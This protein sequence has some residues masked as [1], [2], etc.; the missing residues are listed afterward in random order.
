[1]RRTGDELPPHAAGATG[2]AAYR[3]AAV[4]GERPAA[5]ADAQLRGLRE[6][7]LAARRE[8]LA[9]VVERRLAASEPG[10]GGKLT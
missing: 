3:P 2:P 7:G 8:R 10:G 4:R 1:M 5:A 6:E 9:G